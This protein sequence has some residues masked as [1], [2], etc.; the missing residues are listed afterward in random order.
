MKKIGLTL[1]FILLFVFAI[2]FHPSM[3]IHLLEFT[4]PWFYMLFSPQMFFLLSSFL[5]LSI[6]KIKPKEVGITTEP[7]QQNLTWGI[8]LGVA[9]YIL[10]A[11]ANIAMGLTGH[12]GANEGMFEWTPWLFFSYFILAPIAEEAF[13]RGIIFRALSESYSTTTSVIASAV[14][15]AAS[16]SSMMVGPFI[17]GIITAL[18]TK[19]TKS[20]FPGMIVHALSNGLPWFF[21]NHCPN[22][23]IFEQWIFFRF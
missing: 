7:L 8:G 13:F 9:G 21:I 6:Y 20:I 2:A 3:K 10:L 23:Q 18:L 1:P 5:V 19:K 11:A 16:H 14:L 17:L 22:L 15:F 4:N 12:K